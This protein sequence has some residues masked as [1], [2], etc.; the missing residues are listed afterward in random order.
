[1]EPHLPLQPNFAEIAAGFCAW[2]EANAFSRQ[3]ER[4]AASWLARLHASALEL[5]DV[6]P[7]NEDG[8]PSLPTHALASAKRN[9]AYFVGMYYRVVFDPSPE[10]TDEPVIGD[11]GDDLLDIYKD[12]K[13]GL[14]LHEEGQL[15]EA[16]WHWS[17]LHR[18]HWGRHA[19]GA[20]SALYGISA[21]EAG[22]NAL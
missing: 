10:L 2:C 17:F 11:V 12:V 18:I 13:A 22:E 6:E 20:L 7:E 21:G 5:P 8:L 9:L 16:V 3:P 1:M 19:V 15:Q 4:Q 14:T